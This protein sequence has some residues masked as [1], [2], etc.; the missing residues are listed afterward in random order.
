MISVIREN[1]TKPTRQMK[2]ISKLFLSA[3]LIIAAEMVLGQTYNPKYYWHFDSSNPLQDAMGNFNIDPNYYQGAYSILNNSNN[4]GVGKYLELNSTSSHL[5]KAGSMQSSSAFTIEFLFKPG[6]KF[7]QCIFFQRLDGSLS[8]RMAYPYIEFS[9]TIKNGSGQNVV[10]VFRVDLNQVGRKSYGYYMDGNWHHMVFK[11]NAST[12]VKQIWVDGQLPDGF[13]KATTTGTINTA[14]S[15]NK[16]LVF[17]HSVNYIKYFGSLDEIAVYEYDL[18]Q[19]MI[20]KHYNEAINDN[21][22]YS[23]NATSATP[24]TASAVTAPIDV[25]E[26]APGHPNV[27]VS[28]LDQLRSYPA[29]RYKKGNTL[30][31]NIQFFD[32]RYLGG[33]FQNGVTYD[34]AV[35]SSKEIQKELVFHHNYAWMIS[36]THETPYFG[37]TTK[38][39]G[40]WI[41]LA[42]TYPQYKTSAF[43]YWPQLDPRAIGKPISNAYVQDKDLHASHYLKNSNGQFIDFYGNTVSGSSKIWSPAAPLDSIKYDGLTQ[44]FYLDELTKKLTRPLDLI[45]ENGEVFHFSTVT[46]GYQADPTVNSQK[47]SSGLSWNDYLGTKRKE[48]SIEYRNKFM[49][50]PKLANTIYAEYQIDGHPQYRCGYGPLR[51]VNTPINGQNYATGD[52]YTRYPWNWRYWSSA[53]HGWQWLVDCRN[54]ELSYGDKLFSPAVSPGW[55]L[56]EEINVRPAQYLG[57]LKSYAMTGAEFFYSAYFVT[58]APYQ[59]PKNYMWQTVIP[60]YAQGVTSYYEDLLRNGNVMSGDVPNDYVNPTGAGYTFNTGNFSHLVVARKHNTKNI[61][62]I[63]GSVQPNS[64]MTGNAP[65]TEMATIE[66][67]G[68][69][70]TF[71]IRRQG[72]TYFY[73]KTNASSPIFYQIDKWH[74]FEHPSRW[75][76]DFYFEAEV[77]DLKTSSVGIKTSVP[78]GTPAGNY[79]NYTSYIQFTSNGTV[80]YFFTPRN[81]TSSSTYYVWVRARSKN[82]QSAGVNISLNSSNTHTLDCIKDTDWKWYRLN[83][84]SQQNM[85]FT[86][87][88]STEQKLTLSSINTNIEIDQIVLSTSSSNIFSATSPVC[89][90]SVSANITANGPTQFC[91]GSS[92]VLTANSS[93]SYVWN[94]G[95]TTQSITVS[96]GG[97]YIVT[98]TLNGVGSAVSN[99]VDI[100][101]F[102]TTAAS[103]DAEGPTTFCEGDKVRLKANTSSSYLWSTGETTKGVTVKIEDVYT[104]TVTDENG[105]SSTATQFIDVKGAPSANLNISPTKK[106]CPGE[107]VVLSAVVSGN[108]YLWSTGATTQSITVLDSGQ[109]YVTITSNAGC[110]KISSKKRIKYFKAPVATISASGPLVFPSGSS[111]TLTSS[112]GTSYLWTPGNINQRDITVSNTGTYRV[113]VTN[114]NG[115]TSLSN[116]V[117]VIVSGTPIVAANFNMFDH[118]QNEQIRK[119]NENNLPQNLVVYPNPSTS[120]VNLVLDDQMKGHFSLEMLDLSGRILLEEKLFL[121]DQPN[122]YQIDV[123]HLSDGVYFLR[124]IGSGKQYSKKISVKH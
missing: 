37:D 105:C 75:S 113:R 73:D 38:F 94:T 88:P 4:N 112:Y 116:P 117:N 93:S 25:N 31:P 10:D 1:Q 108:Q 11:Y 43:A 115:C 32:A 28:A 50:L 79:S 83:T 90:T 102:T 124:L 48:L 53:W 76:K 15:A 91:Q 23:F 27:N 70:L 13:S 35:N 36:P 45:A 33:L 85:K 106:V 58:T 74:Q 8:A 44:K 7:N 17:N 69:S 107:P 16:D 24:P 103:I 67:D 9:T 68:Q 98:V 77:M 109:Y 84:S 41:K 12:G 47:N 52:L 122:S 65:K 6:Y 110:T 104:V 111:V 40:A 66:L 100:L 97:S 114:G 92:V 78:S 87:V 57:L 63:T 56:N 29:S 49:S 55:D 80:D 2:L 81:N 22:H 121:E 60:S 89:A 3:L 14:S 96:S 99:P 71:E 51:S 61:Y 101:V 30:L 21:S 62:A 123:E 64:N 86:N 18:N 82:G 72:S 118:E 119:S 20:Y 59:D 120:I 5:I 19:N 42:N 26:F 95:A 34:Q 54:V 39:A 46:T